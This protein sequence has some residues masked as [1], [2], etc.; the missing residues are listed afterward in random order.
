VVSL[1]PFYIS[2]T[3]GA[4][5][6]VYCASQPGLES[7]S[8]AYLQRSA[9]GNWGAVGI[10]QPNDAAQDDAKAAALWNLSEKLIANAPG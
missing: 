5:P 4:G 1:L 6:S 9:F 10:T 2:T 3:A 7:Q 8:G